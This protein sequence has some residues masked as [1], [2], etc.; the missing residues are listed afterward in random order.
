LVEHEYMREIPGETKPGRPSRRF[1]LN[2]A[3]IA[4]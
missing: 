4:A 2:K 3:A 1:V